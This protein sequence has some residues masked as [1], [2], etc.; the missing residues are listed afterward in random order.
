MQEVLFASSKLSLPVGVRWNSYNFSFLCLFPQGFS[1]K[2][3]L[4]FTRLVLA[5]FRFEVFLLSLT[6][7]N[8][9]P[10]WQGRGRAEAWM[11]GHM[12]ATVADPGL[13]AGALSAVPFSFRHREVCLTVCFLGWFVKVNP[14]FMAGTWSPLEAVW[15]AGVCICERETPEHITFTGAAGEYATDGS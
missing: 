2:R 15:S 7:S 5:P 1:G 9:V 4:C 3:L 11:S 12:L 8:S 6:Y 14:F 10:R 13:S